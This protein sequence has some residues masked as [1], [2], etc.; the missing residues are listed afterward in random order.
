MV[1]RAASVLSHVEYATYRNQGF[2][3]M[4]SV[5]YFFNFQ[6]SYQNRLT[7]SPAINCRN[8]APYPFW[9]ASTVA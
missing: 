5:P 3:G 7:L 9:L 6:A 2:N 1:D 8:T 4:H